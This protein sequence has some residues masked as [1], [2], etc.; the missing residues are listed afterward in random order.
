LLPKIFDLLVLPLNG[1]LKVLSLP[2]DALAFFSQ[3][4]KL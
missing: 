3:L 1:C 4:L 2:F